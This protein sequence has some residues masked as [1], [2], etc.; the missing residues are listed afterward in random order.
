MEKMYSGVQQGWTGSPSVWDV[1]HALR[2]SARS[3][4][5]V[6]SATKTVDLLGLIVIAPGV[7]RRAVCMASEAQASHAHAAASGSSAV[8]THVHVCIPRTT[9]PRNAFELSSRS[10]WSN[11][12]CLRPVDMLQGDRHVRQPV[13]IHGVL[14][15]PMHPHQSCWLVY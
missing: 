6:Y 9:A 1:P 11:V 8:G 7:R 2:T 13:R 4:P 12:R 10:V 14:T 15:R 5:S 3:L